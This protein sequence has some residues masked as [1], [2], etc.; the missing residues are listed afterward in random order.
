MKTMDELKPCPFCGGKAIFEDMGRPLELYRIVCTVCGA[1]V[2]SLKYP[3]IPRIGEKVAIAK[4][5]K[6]IDGERRE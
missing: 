1:N 4:W 3:R 2:T 6:R 5:N